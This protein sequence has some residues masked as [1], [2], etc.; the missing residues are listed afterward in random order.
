MKVLIFG[1][2]YIGNRLAKSIEGS[3]L[4]INK[5]YTINEIHTAIKQNSPNVVI[6]CIG[7]VG[8]P[9]IDWCESN[10]EETFFTNV[11]L[12]FLMRE[13]CSAL[14]IKMVHIS[15]GCIYE[16]KGN[17]TEDD[18]PNF[19]GSFYSM[20]KEICEDGLKH[21]DVLQLRIRMPIDN[22]VNPR[23][24]L[25]KLLNYDEIINEVN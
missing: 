24:L 7:K 22:I 15:T 21:F 3:V 23:N 4:C 6:N 11:T 9:N 13:V 20:T 12:P 8:R 2:G 5:V 16:G 1:N 18:K 19:H 14:D 25:T 10:K 17:Y